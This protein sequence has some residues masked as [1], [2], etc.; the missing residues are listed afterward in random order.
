MAFI[1]SIKDTYRA[2]VEAA[3]GGKNTVMYDD[4]GNPSIMVVI[5]KFYLNDVITGAP[6]TVHPA[7]VVNGI[8]KECNLYKQVPKH[9]SEWKG[10]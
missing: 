6:H 10:I 7:F 1:Y 9:S 8:E 2:A 4:Q 3:S 5:P